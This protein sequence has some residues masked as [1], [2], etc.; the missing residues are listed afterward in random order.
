MLLGKNQ[1]INI[2]VL[3]SPSSFHHVGQITKYKADTDRPTDLPTDR[4]TDRMHVLLT[5]TPVEGDLQLTVPK[6]ASTS[7]PLIRI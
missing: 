4:P 3:L 5:S 1:R 6:S 7:S 2:C